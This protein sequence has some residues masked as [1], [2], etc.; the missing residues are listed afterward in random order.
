MGQGGRHRLD[1]EPGI[2]NWEL[3]ILAGLRPATQ[4]RELEI[5]IRATDFQLF[6][7]PT[8]TLTPVKIH[9]L[10]AEGVLELTA[11]HY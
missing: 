9:P 10:V 8:L 4:E 5:E 7:L 11:E 3:G 2:G 6:S 1:G